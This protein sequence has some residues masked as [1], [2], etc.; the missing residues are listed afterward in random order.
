MRR[1]PVY[2]V[3]DKSYSMAGE[4]IDA[5]NQGLQALVDMLRQDPFALETVHLSVI[6]FSS[7]AEHTVGLSDLMTFQP[8]TLRPDGSTSLGAALTL[9][10]E[11]IRREVKTATRDAKG[12]WRPLVFV[13]TD[14]VANDDLEAGV[15]AMKNVSVAKVVGCAAGAEA[16]VADLQRFATDVVR[17]DS[18]DAESIRAF[19]AWVSASVSMTSQSVE[20]GGGDGVAELPPPPREINVIDLHKD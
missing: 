15:Q 5:V 20:S 7:K 18:N 1:L 13:F 3:L 12:D 14:G 6:E 4:P 8:P 17:L 2:L 19:F 9:T 11:G 10:A 16:D